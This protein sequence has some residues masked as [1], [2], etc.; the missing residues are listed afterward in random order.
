[1]SAIALATIGA[2][3]RATRP[4]RHI[5]IARLVAGLPLLAIGLAH[6]LVAD[7]GMR[8]LVEAAGL[9]MA[10]VLA[11][12]AVA[13][14]LV[15]GVSLLLGAFA[16]L[17][18]LLAVPTMAVAVYSHLTIDVWPN[19]AENEPPLMLP[20]AVVAGA[21]YV[22]WRGAGRWSLDGRTARP[23]TECGRAAEGGR[24]V[25]GC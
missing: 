13:V 8:P 15:A 25:S 23:R 4:H 3:P 18:A 14:E 22:L 7:A 12:L 24:A 17:G 16:R 19:G 2:D 11:P 1:M 10:A 5:V 6:V 9:P 21:L 20:L